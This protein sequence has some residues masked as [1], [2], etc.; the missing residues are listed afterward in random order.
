MKTQRSFCLIFP[1][2]LIS[3]ALHAQIGSP[4]CQ[5]TAVPAIVRAEGVAEKLGDILINCTGTPGR[6]IVGNLGLTI[7]TTVTNRIL[8][9]GSLDVGLAVNGGQANA[10][11][12]L[13]GNGQITFPGLKFTFT[14]AG[15]AELRIS[16]LRGDASFGGALIPPPI[17]PGG[18]LAFPG[19]P[20]VAQISFNSGLLNF[21]NTNFTIGSPQRSLLATTLTGNVPSQFG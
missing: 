12:T 7:N 4:T 20:I 17:F 9:N 8:G 10:A 14:P 18:G 19:Q 11:A 5:I 21:T 3:A 6:E 13:S 1:F 16:N 2:L 15:T